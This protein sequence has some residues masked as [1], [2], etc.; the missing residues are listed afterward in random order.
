MNGSKLAETATDGS[1]AGAK[2]K[3]ASKAREFITSNIQNEILQAQSKS[4]Y[5]KKQNYSYVP[6]GNDLGT[7]KKRN[8]LE[9][10]SSGSIFWRQL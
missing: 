1:P 8:S 9:D 2:Q 4:E 6:N 5:T 7:T 3:M 10:E